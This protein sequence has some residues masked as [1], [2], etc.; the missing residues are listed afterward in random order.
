MVFTRLLVTLD[1]SAT[2]ERVLPYA[3]TFARALKLPVELLTVVDVAGFLTSVERARRFDDLIQNA[4]REGDTYL[5]GVAKRFAGSRVKRTVEQGS[6]AEAIIETAAADKST[7]IAMTTHGRSG[8]NRWL[9][10]SVAEKVLR[11]TINPLLLVR[12]SPQGT[13]DGEATLSSIVVPLDGSP[14][15]DHVL[16][17]VAQ[18]AKKLGIEIFLFR[19]YGNPYSPFIS[20]GGHYAVDVDK[21]LTDIRDEARK[22]L[23]EKLAQ[24]KKHGIEEISYLIQEGDAADQIV[25][26]AHDTADS[27]IVICSHG[28]SG[29]KRW[30][31]GSVTE[32]VVRHSNSPVLVLRPEVAGDGRKR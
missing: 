4:T 19:A 16:P 15:A 7:L 8:L 2:A 5:Q 24:L 29:V 32:T 27:L 28:R 9:L 11:A 13:A 30:A 20:G 3:R 12:A 17:L 18:I 25:S 14:L 31:L 21:L 6:A 26:M 1:G 23:E 22:Y 10:G